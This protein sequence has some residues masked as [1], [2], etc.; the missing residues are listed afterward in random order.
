MRPGLDLPAALAAIPASRC[1]AMAMG[2]ASSLQTVSWW[3]SGSDPSASANVRRARRRSAWSAGVSLLPPSS[4]NVTSVR[5]P[6]RQSLPVTAHGSGYQPKSWP[7][8]RFAQARTS[9]SV[10]SRNST[11]SNT[12]VPMPTGSP[13]Y[14][15]R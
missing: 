2:S 12:S 14:S 4:Q 13:R 9:A 10:S 3:Y 1:P 7:Q 11:R 6:G 8:R 5:W 15:W